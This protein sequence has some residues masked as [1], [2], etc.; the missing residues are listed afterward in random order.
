MGRG[1]PKKNLSWKFKICLKIQRISHY[2]F[3]ASGSIPTKHFPYDVPRGRGYYI[4]ITLKACPLNF[5]RAKKTSKIQRDFWQLST[6]I[7]NISGTTPDIQNLK[8]MWSTAIPPAFQEKKSGELWSTNKKVLLARIEPPKWIFCGILYFSPRNRCRSH[9]FQ[10]LD[11]WSH[12]EIFAIKVES[13]QKSRWI[14]D[15]FSPSQILGGQPSKSYTNVMTPA[16]WH[17]VWKMFCGD[18]P[19]SPEVIV[20]NTPN[21]KP[22]FKFSGLKFFGG[23][24][25]ALRVCAIKAWSISSACKIFRAQNPLWAE[26]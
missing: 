7:A 25:V 6:L 8:E 4:G 14:L 1:S 9:F 24:P 17:V 20:A 11:I 5:G 22:N 26:I 12:P 2:N 13:C 10:I 15:V 3:G 16:S 19:T 23:T 21:F 18:T